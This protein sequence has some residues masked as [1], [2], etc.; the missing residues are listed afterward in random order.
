MGEGKDWAVMVLKGRQAA[1]VDQ[2][3]EDWN[4]H[5]SLPEEGV[6]M[7]ITSLVSD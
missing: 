3:I 7:L 1:E 5:Q 6:C 2:G 4:P